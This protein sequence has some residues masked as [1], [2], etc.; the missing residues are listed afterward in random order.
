MFSSD[1]LFFS[2]SCEALSHWVTDY[3]N[4][5]NS[6]AGTYEEEQVQKDV[7]FRLSLFLSISFTI[8]FESL[9]YW[10]T[11]YTNSPNS[12]AG[13][14]EEKQVQKDVETSNAHTHQ[15]PYASL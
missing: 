9:G 6:A 13:T 12:A 5:P 2:L 1:S 4:S 14:Y 3:T 11:N 8:S 15:S 7:Q 10:V